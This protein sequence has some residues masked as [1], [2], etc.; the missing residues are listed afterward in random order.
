MPVGGNWLHEGIAIVI[1]GRILDVVV[2]GS[3][4]LKFHFFD[5]T[6][7]LCPSRH[8]EKLCSHVRFF[9]NRTFK[10]FR[11]AMLDVSHTPSRTLLNI[12]VLPW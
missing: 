12:M 9:S 11:C 5:I 2:H 1:S 4:R 3:T 8:A 7:C 10:P 6:S